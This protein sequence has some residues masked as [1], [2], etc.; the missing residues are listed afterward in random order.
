[1]RF[2]GIEGE[3]VKCQIAT[4]LSIFDDTP[5]GKTRAEAKG[6]Y[7]EANEIYCPYCAGLSWT[8]DV[9]LTY[10]SRLAAQTEKAMYKA[11]IRDRNSRRVEFAETI[12]YLYASI[13][14][15]TGKDN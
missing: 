1:M 11:E 2:A 14:D 3:F 5:E 4:C 7:L 15:L 8:M 13:L 9:R 12:S 10:K 6:W